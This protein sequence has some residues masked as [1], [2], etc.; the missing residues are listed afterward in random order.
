[1]EMGMEY[2]EDQETAL[3][4]TYSPSA[5]V[6]TPREYE[7]IHGRRPY[8]NLNV[9]SH[10]ND[11]EFWRELNSFFTDLSEPEKE[12]IIRDAK[13]VYGS[14]PVKLAVSLY[15]HG[16]S[17]EKILQYLHAKGIEMTAHR[18]YSLCYHTGLKKV[19]QTQIIP[20]E[21]V[22][23]EDLFNVSERLL[24]VLKKDYYKEYEKALHD[25]EYMGKKSIT[26]ARLIMKK[27]LRRWCV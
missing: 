19:R 3:Y 10:D 2:E 26:V 12:I 14:L 9:I 11:G 13:K 23:P 27:V 16:Y 20:F 4:E 21:R 22:L 25:P 24:E 18:L 7:Q 8:Y 17:V 5:P 1:M 6:L 15:A